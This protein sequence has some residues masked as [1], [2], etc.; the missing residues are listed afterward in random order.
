MLGEEK[1]SIISVNLKKYAR[2]IQHHVTDLKMELFAK[3]VNDCK[4]WT[5]FAKEHHF[6]C[7]ADSEFAS[8]YNKSM[9][10]A[11]RPISS[12]FGKVALTT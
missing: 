9:F 6:R 7:D 8:Y 5:I 10:L 1:T 12:F 4:L 3:I 11:K 2:Q